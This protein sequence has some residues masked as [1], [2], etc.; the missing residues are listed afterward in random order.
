MTN[1][2]NLLEKTKPKNPVELTQPVNGLGEK[3]PKD[4]QIEACTN[5]TGSWRRE[6]KDRYNE[7]STQELV[8]KINEYQL[9]LSQNNLIEYLGLADLF[10]ISDIDKNKLLDRV[11]KIESYFVIAFLKPIT[12]TLK[13]LGNGITK[14]MAINAGYHET[15]S[16]EWCRIVNGGIVI[17]REGGVKILMSLINLLGNNSLSSFGICEGDISSI[18]SAEGTKIPIAS[19]EILLQEVYTFLHNEA[20]KISNLFEGYKLITIRQSGDEI[21][22]I[23]I[24]ENSF[25]LNNSFNSF[26]QEIK[27]SEIQKIIS[28]IQSNKK[29]DNKIKLYLENFL[30]SKNFED[31]DLAKDAFEILIVTYLVMKTGENVKKFH[32]SSNNVELKDVEMDFGPYTNSSNGNFEPLLYDIIGT[33][34]GSS[35]EFNPILVEIIKLLV[36]EFDLQNAIHR[37][38]LKYKIQDPVSSPKTDHFLRHFT[39]FNYQDIQNLKEDYLEE[40]LNSILAIE[41]KNMKS[42]N[43]TYGTRIADLAIAKI[44]VIIERTIFEFIDKLKL[45]EPQKGQV[46]DCLTFSRHRGYKFFIGFDLVELD[47]LGITTDQIQELVKSIQK[48]TQAID[49]FEPDSEQS[50]VPVKMQVLTNSIYHFLKTQAND[51]LTSFEEVLDEI[52]RLLDFQSASQMLNMIDRLNCDDDT[53]L[54]NFSKDHDLISDQKQVKLFLLQYYHLFTDSEII[55]IVDEIIANDSK[56]SIIAIKISPNKITLILSKKDGDLTL[57]QPYTQHVDSIKYYEAKL[58]SLNFSNDSTLSLTGTSRDFS[59]LFGKRIESYIQR[60]ESVNNII[61]KNINALKNAASSIVIDSNELSNMKANL[62]KKILTALQLFNS[63]KYQ[64]DNEFNDFTQLA[65]ELNLIN[66]TKEK[67]TQLTLF[68]I[69]S[70]LVDNSYSDPS[71]K[72]TSDARVISLL[73]NIYSQLEKQLELNAKVLD[74]LQEVKVSK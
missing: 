66:Q 64:T 19:S 26:L 63:I 58:C 42:V 34:E 37:E 28:S 36:P 49:I 59:T 53:T 56:Y 48:N 7:V 57:H 25:N 65:T 74:I 54:I 12:H 23:N 33:T 35:E 52:D 3:S 46:I 69:I 27:D 45:D 11:S 17:N 51:S 30:N 67:V 18:Q 8:K 15:N 38:Y 39:T 41:V 13:N 1:T 9:L 68:E 10:E 4:S 2:T 24:F 40:K 31:S 16:N 6:P 47:K 72:T 29:I 14:E 71:D 5:I 32:S 20:I 21:V 55:K 60:L 61:I 43:T 62:T 22:F 70:K 44:A 73:S 50:E